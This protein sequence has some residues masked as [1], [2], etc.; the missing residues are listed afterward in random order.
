MPKGKSKPKPLTQEQYKILIPAVVAIFVAVIGCFGGIVGPILVKYFEVKVISTP[1]IVPSN[2]TLPKNTPES[3]V[4][5]TEVDP[6]ALGMVQGPTPGIYISK[7]NIRSRLQSFVAHSYSNTEIPAESKICLIN[8]GYPPPERRPLN[9]SAHSITFESSIYLA[10]NGKLTITGYQIFIEHNP[11]NEKIRSLEILTGGAG[12]DGGMS[13]FAILELPTVNISSPIQSVYTQE[14]NWLDLN[15][16]EGVAFFIP[17]ELGADGQYSIQ[18]KFSFIFT[19]QDPNI[20]SK[21]SSLT[22]GQSEYS[23]LLINDPRSY[24]ISA[25]NYPVNLVD[26]P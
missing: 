23:W 12:G 10:A 21:Q 8:K 4:P 19:S 18:V 2:S 9:L 11:I 25:G 7:G 16:G 13:P 3:F 15:K 17:I 26:C 1:S 14:M 5:Y 22:T 20:G 24:N 6:D